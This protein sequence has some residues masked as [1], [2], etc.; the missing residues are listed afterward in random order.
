MSKEKRLGRGLEALLGK[1]DN[2]SPTSAGTITLGSMGA[3]ASQAS[4]GNPG[5]VGNLSE[6]VAWVEPNEK[7]AVCEIPIE[8]IEPNP[9]QPRKELDTAEIAQLADSLNNHGLLQPIVVRRHRG[10][11]QLI[12]GERRCR[13]AKLAGWDKVPARVVEADDQQLAELAIV[14]NLQ[15]KDLNALEKAYCFQRYLEE[16][17]VTQEELASR[18]SLDRSTISNFIRLLDLPEAVQQALRQGKITQGHARALLSL[19]SEEEQIALCERIQQEGLSVR[20]IEQMVQERQQ[21]KKST[22]MVLRSGAQNG[23]KRSP[24]HVAVLEQEFRAA[25]GLRVAL[26]HNGRGKGKL[27]IYFQSHEEFALLRERICGEERQRLA[28]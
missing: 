23:E 20:R 17:G 16:Y 28:G 13:A 4:L 8:D 9:F 5:P 10:R 15:R 6:N 11:Y 1:L 14:E 7:N 22:L 19:D 27:V 18:L 3:E 12:A 25:L 26:T 2:S 24:E 21:E